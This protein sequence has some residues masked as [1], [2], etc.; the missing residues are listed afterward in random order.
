VADPLIETVDRLIKQARPGGQAHKR[1]LKYRDQL[2]RNVF[3]GPSVLRYIRG[4]VEKLDDNIEC[5]HLTG[6][7]VCREKKRACDHLEDNRSCTI[8]D[9]SRP[10]RKRRYG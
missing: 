9:P 8:Y 2:E 6:R 1:L 10:H 4:L 3:L 5:R 7:G